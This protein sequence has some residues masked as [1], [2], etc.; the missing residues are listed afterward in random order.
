M[1]RRL[2]HFIPLVL[3]SLL[4]ISCGETDTLSKPSIVNFAPSANPVSSG[5]E[6][7]LSWTVNGATSLSIDNGV[8]DVTGTSTVVRPTATTTYTLTATNAAGDTSA[9]T[10]V[11]V[12]TAAPGSPVI[13]SFTATPDN[14]AAG[15]TSTLS[16]DVT[17]ATSLSIDNGVGPVTGTSA[18]VNPTVTTTYTLEATNDNGTVRSSKVVTV[19]TDTGG[20]A[21]TGDFGVSATQNGTFTND[22]PNNIKDASDNRIVRVQPGGTFY[23]RVTYSDPDGIE[24]IEVNLVNGKPAGVAGTLDPTQQFFTLGDATGT[25]DLSSNPKDVTCVYPITVDEDAK[26]ITAL[27]NS[28]DEFAYVFRTKVTDTLNNTSDEPNRG[29]VIVGQGNGGNPGNPPANSAPN[30]TIANVGDLTLSTDGNVET[31]LDATVTDDEDDT[32]NYQWSVS[33]DNKDSVKFSSATSEDTDATFSAVGDYTLKLTAT[34]KDDASSA[35]SATVDITVNENDTPDPPS[36]PSVNIEPSKPDELTLV[37]GTAT[38]NLTAS[39]DNFDGDVAY[40]WESFSGGSSV[41]GGSF[42]PANVTF[43]PNGSTE[44]ANT[45]ATFT[46]AGTYIVAVTAEDEMRGAE[47]DIEVTVINPKLTANAGED[48]PN[49]EV[50]TLVNLNGS[51]SSD[52]NENTLSYSWTI[53]G[54]PDGSTATLSGETTANPS[55]TPDVVGDYLIELTVTNS[56]D[57]SDTD[58]VTITAVDFTEPTGTFGVSTNSSGPFLNDSEDTGGFILSP[59]DPRIVDVEPASIFFALVSYSGA[60]GITDI[61]IQLRNPSPEGISGPLDPEQQFFIVGQP[62]ETEDCDLS[63]EKT[64]ITCIYPIDV[65]A[66]AV[67]IDELEGS[68][69]EFAYVFRTQVTDSSRNTSYS[70]PRGYVMVEANNGGN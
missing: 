39:A 54:Q 7:T 3:L 50:G 35:G 42:A 25:C 28:G 58:S 1:Q 27:A 22:K 60:G 41:T 69:D 63:G 8:G 20:T 2:Q 65:F 48:Q 14:I 51:A 32:F 52:P 33:S 30:V 53:A 9:R 24:D 68:N 31:S 13:N 15:G 64:S 37:D 45:T 6:V 29:Y 61:V 40:T 70:S 62:L 12:E 19:G 23:A 11:T 4:I 47:A 21:P 38:L 49:A 43:T 46:E 17:G 5:A 34:D 36:N 57:D 44:A 18:V 10:T 26:N 67:N 59:D 56:K 55:F 16:W 66:D